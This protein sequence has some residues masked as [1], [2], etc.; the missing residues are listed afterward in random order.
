LRRVASGP[1]SRPK[2][3]Q[4]AS[5]RCGFRPAPVRTDTSAMEPGPNEERQ[6]VEQR[7]IDFSRDRWRLTARLLDLPRIV[8][9]ASWKFVLIDA[10]GRVRY[11]GLCACAVA[12]TAVA[13]ATARAQSARD[14][15]PPDL[16]S[17]PLLPDHTASLEGLSVAVFPFLRSF[18]SNRYWRRVQ[19]L[20]HRSRVLNWLIHATAATAH[21][22]NHEQVATH[23]RKTASM[24]D[25]PIE[26]RKAADEAALAVE[27]QRWT[28]SFTLSH[29]DF[30]HGNIM[31]PAKAHHSD[32]PFHVVDWGGST[33]HGYA[34]LDLLRSL[35]AFR[36]GAAA[37][38]NILG[39]FG[40]SIAASDREFTY[41]F[42]AA[43]GH[44]GLNLNHFPRDRFAKLVSDNWSAID[45]L[46]NGTDAVSRTRR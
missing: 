19:F 45:K 22:A 20:H 33:L 10:R 8:P 11:F 5:I 16:R 7:L 21:P 13:D 31:L 27:K 37:C 34:I 38:R 29:G 6:Q 35:M 14:A 40:E 3:A 17:V 2:K 4:G 43:V 41:Y 26:L 15:L 44:L 24:S 28:P 1:A 23:C 36:F 9:D 42:A 18:S 12:P 25:L 39:R 32:A 46:L 30:W